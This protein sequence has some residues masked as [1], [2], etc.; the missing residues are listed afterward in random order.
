MSARSMGV[1]EQRDGEAVFTG[2][3]IWRLRAF[4]TY[5]GHL[6]RMSGKFYSSDPGQF[7]VEALE[8]TLI[9]EIP[10]GPFS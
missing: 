10:Y 8:P 4:F 9:Y 7:Y 1:V 3:K 2:K 6:F 5:E